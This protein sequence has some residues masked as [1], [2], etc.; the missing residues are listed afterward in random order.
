MRVF[1]NNLIF[2]PSDLANHISCRHLTQLN[3]LAATGS[4]EKPYTSNRVLEV[5]R[6]KGIAFEEQ[7][8][9]ELESQGKSIVVISRDSN[10]PHKE[11][12]EAMISGVDI[13]YQ[14]KLWEDGEWEGWADFLIKVPGSSAFGDW[15]Y[16]VVDTK[17][18]SETRA[19]TI[20]QIGL[21][22]EAVARMQGVQPEYMHIKT[23]DSQIQYRVDDFAAYVRLVKRNLKDAIQDPKVTYPDP[24]PHCDICNWWEHCNSQRRADDH[25][26]FVAGLGNNHTKELRIH[27]VNSLESLAKLP[28]PI[29]FTPIRGAKETYNK[30][31]EQAR[32]QLQGKVEKRPVFELLDLEPGTGFYKLPEPSNNDIYLD[33]EGDPL[34]EASGLEYLIGWVHQGNYYSIWSQNPIEEK[35]AFEAFI[36]LVIENK[37]CDPSLHIYHYAPYEPVAFK[38]LMSKYATR[39]NEMDGLLRSGAF[40]DLYGVVRQSIRASVE[41]YSIKD[42]EKFYR[43]ERE[44]DLRELSSFKADFEFLMELGLTQGINEE[45]KN[46]IQ[47]YNQDDCIST[48]KLH[49]WL[50]S[51]RQELIDTGREIPRPQISNGDPSEA[52]TAHQERIQPLMDRLLLDVPF[53]EEERNLEQQARYILAHMLDWYR[54]EK[55]SFWWEYFRLIELPD[56]ELLEERGAI[57]FLEFTGERKSIKQSVIDTYRFP[58]QESDI[59]KGLVLRT[60]DGNSFGSVEYIDFPS[61]ILKI[62]KGPSK[63]DIHPFSV[64]SIENINLSKKEE[65]L[66][67]LAEWVVEN[68]ISNDSPQYSAGRHLLLRSKPQVIENVPDSEDKVEFALNWAKRLDHSILPIQGP[69]GTGKSHT[70]AHVVLGLVNEGKR[71]GITALSHKV[72]S[73]LMN[74]IHEL[75]IKDHLNIEM[76]QKV[77]NESESESHWR[78]T[79]D[80][81]EILQKLDKVQVI[82]G[83]SFFWCLQDLQDSVDYLFIDEAGQLSLID[84]LSV[85]GACKNLVLLGDPQQ[86]QQPQKGV[87]PSGTEVSALGHILQQ[88]QTISEDQGIFLGVTWRMHPKVCDFVSEMFYEGRLLPKGGLENQMIEG[89]APL[90]GFGLRLLEVNHQGNT[91]SSGEEVEVVLRLVIELLSGGATWKDGEGKQRALTK[92]DIRIISPYNA[93]VNLLKEAL[94][95]I[96]IG[97]VDKFQ[98]QEAPVVIYSMA[99]SNPQDAPRGMDFL[100]SPNRFNVAVSRAKA[101]FILVASPEIF[102]PECKSP[103]QI[104][105]ANPFCRYTEVSEKISS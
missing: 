58:S 67:S 38:R 79:T 35:K 61:G 95:D 101:L 8:L 6:E 57:A 22:S 19:G 1:K 90:S 63:R 62:K 64:F 88:S 86:L 59:R 53:D 46:A 48:Q 34:I 66:I 11:V 55:K 14:A 10:T 60:Q 16:E 40:V 77:S 3:K 36:D 96:E 27:Y 80:K 41:K 81:N 42:L 25:L 71:V 47:L 28:N 32:I 24:V 69:P 49:E 54:R 76:I 82:G 43:Y 21:Y 68:G 51:L 17:L 72:I 52:I 50:E 83:T 104:R 26:G 100:Y 4:L 29:P 2:S 84:T 70:G 44:M 87:H 13:I 9:Q 73:N 39:E 37:S 85:S 65:A 75:A 18:T 92:D 99:T 30:L 33:L 15:S 12:L 97:T 7:Y 98:G 94:P 31:R 56:D 23:P 5:L 102:E 93:Q 103:G 105:L 89:D 91:N 20:L 78:T 45:M 74:K